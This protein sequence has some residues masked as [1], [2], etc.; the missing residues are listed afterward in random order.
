MVERSKYI[1]IRVTPEEVD[2][3]KERMEEAGIRSMTAYLLR[4][5]LNGFV[6]VMDLSDLKEILRLLQI[7][8][9]NLNQY[10]K[11]ANETRSI[12]REDIEELKNNQKEILQEMRKMLDKLTAIM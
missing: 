11:R 3:I 12:Y 6:I 4:M 5:A 8:G 1:H 10:A 7:S 9:N 2:R